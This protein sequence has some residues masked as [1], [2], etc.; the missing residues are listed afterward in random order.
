MSDICFKIYK[1]LLKRNADRHAGQPSI[2]GETVFIRLKIDGVIN[3]SEFAVV[4]TLR[5]PLAQLVVR[6][7]TVQFFSIIL[8]TNIF[9]SY[10]ILFCR[11]KVSMD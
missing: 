5:N 3:Q 1:T 10:F 7:H 9:R 8:Y 11:L 2:I 6:T 4:T